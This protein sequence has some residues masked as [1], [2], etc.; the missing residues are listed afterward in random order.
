MVGKDKY[1]Y[2]KGL[3][4]KSCIETRLFTEHVPDLSVE[5]K[6]GLGWS[7]P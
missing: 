2:F 3:S 1:L 5:L 4:V 7:Q 6:P